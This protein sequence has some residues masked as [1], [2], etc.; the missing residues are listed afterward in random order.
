M[1]SPKLVSYGNTH[2]FQY[3]TDLSRL[4]HHFTSAEAS[5]LDIET[6]LKNQSARRQ[7]V[8]QH[9]LAGRSSRAIAKEMNIQRAS[10]RST[11]RETMW[12]ILKVIHKL[13]RYHRKG[14]PKGRNY[15]GMK[16]KNLST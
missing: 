12:A 9:V 4:Y 11:L 8:V 7:L 14:R 2:T 15:G 16:F 5:T 1:A 13:P 10:V 6:A 3:P